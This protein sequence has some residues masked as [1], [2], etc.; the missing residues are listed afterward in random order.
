VQLIEKTI[1]PEFWVTLILLLLLSLVFL[2]KVLNANLLKQHFLTL[3]KVPFVDFES[4]ENVGFF[5]TYK[6]VLFLF[7]LINYALF[8]SFLYS[9]LSDNVIISFPTFSG[10][11]GFV[12]L[13]FSIKWFLEYL[14][15]VLF[16]IKKQT[17]TFMVSKWYYLF[18]IS[19][20]INISIIIKVYL[21]FNFAYVLYFIISLFA[22]RFLFILVSNKKLIFNKLFYFILYLCAFEIAPLFI[23]FKL[24]F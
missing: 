21:K 8:F 16:S 1:I 14:F 4:E 9:Y 22:F 13:Y 10:V 15:T 12:I 3:F 7:S 5:D 17:E 11:L 18:S 6:A 20:F 19:F 23:L 2:L 24:M